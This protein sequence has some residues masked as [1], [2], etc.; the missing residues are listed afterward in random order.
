MIT[1]DKKTIVGLA[2]FGL[3]VAG[4]I[5][6]L[7]PLGLVKFF[8]DTQYLLHFIREHRMYAIFIFIGLQFLQ[9]VAA[10]VPGE[11]TGFVGGISLARSGGLFFQ[12]SDLPLARG[13]HSVSRVLRAGRSSK[14]W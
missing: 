3:V 12:P 14:R 4:I 6:L 11:V 7:F 10:P 13:L 1:F 8:T 5:Y 9:V 2:I